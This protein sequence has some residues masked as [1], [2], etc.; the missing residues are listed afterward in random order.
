ML[1]L[2]GGVTQVDFWSQHFSALLPPSDMATPSP[3][4]SLSGVGGGVGGAPSSTRRA[5]KSLDT[6]RLDSTESTRT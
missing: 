6:R 2:G 4:I 3:P 5:E 1:V